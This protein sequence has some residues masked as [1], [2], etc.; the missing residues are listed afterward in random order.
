MIRPKDAARL[1]EAAECGEVARAADE[2]LAPVTYTHRDLMK[3]AEVARKLSVKT[4]TIHQ[5][6]RAGLFPCVKI[7]RMSYVSRK[8]YE[9]WL[10]RLHED[11]GFDFTPEVDT[12][13]QRPDDYDPL[14]GGS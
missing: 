6:Q 12:G 10:R 3:P 5:W 13:P 4:R 7:G 2:A 11:P 1:K 14:E 8:Q 9:E